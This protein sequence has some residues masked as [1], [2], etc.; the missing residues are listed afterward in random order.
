MERLIQ[1]RPDRERYRHARAQVYYDQ[2]RF[3]AAASEVREA[4][5]LESG[6]AAAHDLLGQCLEGSGRFEQA[7]AAYD[8]AISLNEARQ[9]ASPW[10]HFH[11]GSLLHD[12]GD[13]PGA[14]AALLAAVRTD[15][16]HSWAQAELGIV[17]RKTGKPDQAVETLEKAAQLAPSNQS[18]EYALAGLYQDLG[19]KDK[20]AAAPERF[21]Q[22]KQSER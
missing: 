12:L 2:Q 17:L 4:I 20:A 1:D 5:R 9:S 16:E 3:G 7:L 22:M 21:R 6:F 10:P 18:I 19:E 11:R 15:P 13:L 8:R 14:E